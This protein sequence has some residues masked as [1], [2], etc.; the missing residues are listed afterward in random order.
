MWFGR[1]PDETVFVL[2]PADVERKVTSA[3]MSG[4]MAGRLILGLSESQARVVSGNA[5]SS[6]FD[7]RILTL[8]ND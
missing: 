2:P 8:A 7:A 6:H 1:Y 4:D 3:S 5:T